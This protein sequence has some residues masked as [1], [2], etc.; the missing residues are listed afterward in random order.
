MKALDKALDKNS[1]STGLT[2]MDYRERKFITTPPVRGDCETRGNIV[3]W[4]NPQKVGKDL[5]DVVVLSNKMI[6]VIAIK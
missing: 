4:C 3:K 2:P 6:P 1:I 5:Y